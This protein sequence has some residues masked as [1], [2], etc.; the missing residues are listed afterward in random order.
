M[1]NWENPEIEALEVPTGEEGIDPILDWKP[2]GGILGTWI[3]EKCGKEFP[4]NIN[5]AI[6]DARDHERDCPGIPSGS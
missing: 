6:S 5:G 2:G 3:C 1:E 4:A